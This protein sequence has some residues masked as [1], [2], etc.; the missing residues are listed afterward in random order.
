LDEA[1]AA[2]A[3]SLFTLVGIPA[4]FVFGFLCDRA[5]PKW[6]LTFC[7]GIS[8]VVLLLAFLWSGWLGAVIIA[9][10]LA[11]GAGLAGLYGP[12]AAPRIFGPREAGE[13]VGMISVGSA[14]GSTLG[15]L[16]FGFMYDGFGN[17]SIALTVMGIVLVVCLL[18][19]LWA[20]GKNNIANINRQ[21]ERESAPSQADSA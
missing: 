21:I 5:G 17:Y 7:G 9:C 3:F 8:A 4:Q 18:L 12:N 19:N 11:A 2:F 1:S 16:A 20:H 10:G 15:P 14:L 13:M 6:A